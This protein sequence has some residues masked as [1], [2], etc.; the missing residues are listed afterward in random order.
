MYDS[1]VTEEVNGW[2]WSNWRSEWQYVW[3][4]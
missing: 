2:Q 4:M 3:A 1:E